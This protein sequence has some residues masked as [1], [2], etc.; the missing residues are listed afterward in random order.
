LRP[1]RCTQRCL[2]LPPHLR[3]CLPPQSMQHTRTCICTRTR[4]PHPPPAGGDLHRGPQRRPD[5]A[6][7]VGH[8]HL[9]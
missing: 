3:A 9:E 2:A 8:P 1:L 5:D 4:T 7:P 6:V